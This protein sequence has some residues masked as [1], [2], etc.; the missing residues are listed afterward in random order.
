[1]CPNYILAEHLP[2]LFPIGY[3]KILWFLST[4][5]ITQRLT[6][7]RNTHLC[8]IADFIFVS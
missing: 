6:T 5:Y 8:F 7:F 4:C 3:F 1:M 2:K